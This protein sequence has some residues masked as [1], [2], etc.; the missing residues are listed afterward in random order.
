MSN[1]ALGAMKSLE[2][3]GKEH[4]NSESKI[5]ECKGYSVEQIFCCDHAKYFGKQLNLDIQN[6]VCKTKEEEICVLLQ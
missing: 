5:N 2:F 3:A 6:I 4:E 1:T